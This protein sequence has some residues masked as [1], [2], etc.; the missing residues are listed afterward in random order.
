MEGSK[1]PQS[2]NSR[3]LSDPFSDQE[4]IDSDGTLDSYGTLDSGNTSETSS[5]N[6]SGKPVSARKPVQPYLPK[7]PRSHDDTVSI[8]S[9]T[10]SESSGDDEALI[11]SLKSVKKASIVRDLYTPD[12][13]RPIQ[14]FLKGGA[15]SCPDPLPFRIFCRDKNNRKVYIVPPAGQ[16]HPDFSGLKKKLCQR[17]ETH[18]F[19]EAVKDQASALYRN[20]R[21]QHVRAHGEES[22]NL[23]LHR[24][25][26]TFALSELINSP[27]P[28]FPRSSTSTEFDDLSDNSSQFSDDLSTLPD[29]RQ[30]YRDKGK[31][32]DK[33]SADDSVPL[34][35]QDKKTERYQ[36]IPD[37]LS[38]S[39]EGSD[40]SGFFVEPNPEFGRMLWDSLRENCQD[41]D[42]AA[43][44]ENLEHLA[45]YSPELI[46]GYDDVDY[47]QCL[48]GYAQEAGFTEGVELLLPWYR[49]CDHLR[50]ATKKIID[51]HDWVSETSSQPPLSPFEALPEQED[52]S[53]VLSSDSRKSP[54][55]SLQAKESA[56]ANP[57]EFRMLC[58]IVKTGTG[59][60]LKAF[61][62]K[63]PENGQLLLSMTDEN[64]MTPIMWACHP[65]LPEEGV[66]IKNSADKVHMIT[67]L[68]Q[69][70]HVDDFVSHDGYSPLYL[71]C[72]HG[73]N[74]KIA[75]HLLRKCHA[76]PMLQV[77]Q[78]LL[79]VARDMDN[80]RLALL[81]VKHGAKASSEGDIQW[82]Q[83]K[84]K[85]RSDKKLVEELKKN[86]NAQQAN[87]RKEKPA[88]SPSPRRKEPAVSVN[89]DT[90]DEKPFKLEKTITRDSQFDKTPRVT[91]LKNNVPDRE[92]TS[93]L[94][95]VTPFS[96][97]G[98]NPSGF[99]SGVASLTPSSEPSSIKK[100]PVSSLVSKTASV[101]GNSL[102][103]YVIEQLIDASTKG[104]IKKVQDI[105]K[106]REPIDF[107]RVIK[108][109]KTPLAAAAESGHINIMQAL[110][111]AGADPNQ[112]CGQDTALSLLVAQ[113][114]RFKEQKPL[115]R[116]LLDAGADPV[117]GSRSKTALDMVLARQCSKLHHEVMVMMLNTLSEED[118]H[119]EKYNYLLL[120]ACSQGEWDVVLD[121]LNKMG[122]NPNAKGGNPPRTPLE[123][124][125][126]ND[127]SKG[128]LSYQKNRQKIATKLLEKGANASGQEA[129]L[130]LERYFDGD[131]GKASSLRLKSLSK[132]V[133]DRRQTSPMKSPDTSRSS[134]S[135]SPEGHK[136]KQQLKNLDNILINMAAGL[137]GIQVPVVNVTPQ[138]GRFIPF[139]LPF[140][141]KGKSVSS[142]EQARAILETAKG[143]LNKNKSLP[144]VAIT[145]SANEHQTQRIHGNYSSNDWDTA[146]EGGGQAKVM[147]N[148]EV[149]LRLEAYKNLRGKVRIAPITT[150][151]YVDKTGKTAAVG[152]ACM[153]TDKEVEQS[154]KHIDENLLKKGWVVL[155]WQNQK[156]ESTPS[157][158]FAVG[159][160]VSKTVA[161]N[162]SEQDQQ[163]HQ[164]NFIH[165]KLM[166]YAYKYS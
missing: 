64:G 152:T 135:V 111:K 128:D 106:N 40:E 156:T 108:R 75:D 43:F 54:K 9:R 109:F 83:Q 21:Q 59:K 73:K 24:D 114:N 52:G 65:D 148:M 27:A 89:R 158:P 129:R 163:I 157:R 74:I 70:A 88:W 1:P 110:L 123:F 14:R 115:V 16:K 15:P 42:I 151:K 55:V 39:T 26:C 127:H 137:A 76:D 150:M 69:F 33:F 17:M 122:A 160:G 86:W 41:Q 77:A 6:F 102:P 11:E 3:H 154:L 107:D 71:S 50:P 95:G 140:E 31:S 85:S 84:A 63:Q 25:N 117:K 120:S 149:L 23:I 145:Y 126:H 100:S 49:S 155:G 51:M 60:E 105:I 36:P 79:S 162:Q 62:K 28:A 113:L 165:Q 97:D 20:K 146:T 82:F 164:F 116:C 121:A 61:L 133:V 142:T 94:T 90:K 44:R 112:P 131:V 153:A 93:S 130:Y 72:L 47:G 67:K 124:L 2:P 19:S 45:E 68:Q 12:Y 58:D 104:D 91:S 13:V 46:V 143:L 147:K 81:L 56:P 10:V 34:H 139:R 99:K 98:N 8:A 136:P 118:S 32:L 7:S 35:R 141:E 103:D 132:P 18:R 96:D 4:S 30:P 87:E 101:K 125:A 66:K 134:G 92:L 161:R 80:Y 119:E 37:N 22:L 29:R 144:G 138:K 78:P 159:G 48:L 166:E 57:P 38:V 5:A 53:P